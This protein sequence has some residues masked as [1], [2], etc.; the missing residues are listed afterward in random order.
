VRVGT[1]GAIGDPVVLTFTFTAGTGVADVG[2]F[3]VIVTW[4]SVG[5]G[6]SAVVQ[7]VCRA[8]HNSN[9][10]GLIGNPGQVTT[11]VAT[12]SSGFNSSTATN[13]GVSF[14]G[15]TS[16]SATTTLV[17]ASLLQ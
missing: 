16:F 12:T 4:R 15:S 7:G 11:I 17:Q 10:V 1:A 5:S 8:E 6:T 14:N 9:G 13:I 2:I 3:E